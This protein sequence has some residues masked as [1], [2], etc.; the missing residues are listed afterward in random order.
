MNEEQTQ[1]DAVSHK[2]K[3]QDSARVG[4]PYHL[5]PADVIYWLAH[6][7]VYLF[8]YSLLIVWLSLIGAMFG[9]A[10][11]ERGKHWGWI[12]GAIVALIGVPAGQ[13]SFGSKIS[14][15][16]WRPRPLPPD[17]EPAVSE[18]RAHK[19]RP[20]WVT[21]EAMFGAL[22]GALLGMFLGFL[23]LVPCW[24][25]IS[26]SPFAPKGWAESVSYTD[27]AESRDAMDRN[28]DEEVGAQTR[29]PLVFVLGLGP[30]VVLSPVGFLLAGFGMIGVRY[31][32][33]RK[34]GRR[35]KTHRIGKTTE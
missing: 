17:P 31:T 20:I 26:M 12:V 30:P 15:P 21:R 14:H 24:F 1:T 19:D 13:V 9:G 23:V 32:P 3:E 5:R 34:P 29:H 27:P 6:W 10:L 7:M 18:P 33:N 16:P 22:G 2:G 8:L 28:Y 11:G 25:S 35:K 4:R